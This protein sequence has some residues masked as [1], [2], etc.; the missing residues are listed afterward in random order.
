M[1]PMALQPLNRLNCNIVY[2]DTETQ[3]FH[4]QAGKILCVSASLYVKIELLLFYILEVLVGSHLQFVTS[5]L[6]C[7]D[8]TMLVHLQG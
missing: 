8:D 5:R 6:I 2:K 1:P 4:S 3:R 7:N